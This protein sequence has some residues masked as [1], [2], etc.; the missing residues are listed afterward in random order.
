MSIDLLKPIN[1]DASMCVAFCASTKL[2]TI[3]CEVGVGAAAIT[4]FSRKNNKIKYEMKGGVGVVAG[5]SIEVDVKV[6]TDKLM[7]IPDAAADAKHFYDGFR[8]LPDSRAFDNKMEEKI[9]WPK[10]V[11]K[12]D[13]DIYTAMKAKSIK[14]KD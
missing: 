2:I 11:I 3:G 9:Y 13:N 8:E 1:V 12:E 7:A 14:T 6:M 5:F 10:I 4:G